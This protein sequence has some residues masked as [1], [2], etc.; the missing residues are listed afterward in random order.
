MADLTAKTYAE[1]MREIF[2]S[3]PKLVVNLL[4]AFLIYIFGNKVFTAISAR[5]GLTIAGIQVVPII[6]AVVLLS[7]IYFVYKCFGEIRDIAESF[8]KLIAVNIGGG[9]MDESEVKD[10][11]SAMRGILYA[12]ALTALSYFFM[13]VLNGV[14][15]MLAGFA[16][17]LIVIMVILLLFKSVNALN[18]QF[19][20]L[21]KQAADQIL[22]EA[23]KSAKK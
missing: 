7:M 17:V 1:A 12:I 6:N 10:Y 11:S 22:A 2:D 13:D 16:M 19:T 14:H 9:V 18:R 8:G 20:A 3:V 21:G 5:L 23:E 15:G 4:T